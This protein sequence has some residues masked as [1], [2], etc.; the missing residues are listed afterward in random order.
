MGVGDDVLPEKKSLIAVM[1]LVPLA[2]GLGLAAGEAAVLALA[3]GEAE[4]RLEATGEAELT[5]DARGL[6]AGELEA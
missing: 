5:G 6:A 2:L 1:T 3:E 4:A